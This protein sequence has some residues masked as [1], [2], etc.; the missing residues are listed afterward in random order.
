METFAFTLLKSTHSAG[1]IPSFPL[2]LDLDESAGS[3]RG[4]GPA[5]VGTSVSCARS[6]SNAFTPSSTAFAPLRLRGC[7]AEG[8]GDFSCPQGRVLRRYSWGGRTHNEH[9][10]YGVDTDRRS[11]MCN[12]RSARGYVLGWAKEI[13]NV[14]PKQ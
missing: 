6:F 10:P 4:V 5:P 8:E 11:P 14:T 12:G 13:Q 3:C 2:W 1:I 9:R 7:L